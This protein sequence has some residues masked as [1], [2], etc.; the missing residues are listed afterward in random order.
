MRKQDRI[1]N[2]TQMSLLMTQMYPTIL[3]MLKVLKCLMTTM[4]L[5]VYP[6][7][8]MIKPDRVISQLSLSTNL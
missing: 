6:K 5:A 2:Y 7:P 1:G 8:L 4:I 3:S